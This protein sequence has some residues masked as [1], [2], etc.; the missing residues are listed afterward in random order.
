[1]DE[2]QIE[3]T[4]C[5]PKVSFLS[6]RRNELYKHFCFQWYVQVPV[7][8]LLQQRDCYV[9]VTKPRKKI[10]HLSVSSKFCGAFL[11]KENDAFRS[12]ITCRTAAYHDTDT[13]DT[14]QSRFHQSQCPDRVANI[15]KTSHPN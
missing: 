10:E 4:T 14:N 13:S 8:H 9:N 5:L 11:Y 15:Q 7:L 12:S 2:L 1:M 6:Q 3:P